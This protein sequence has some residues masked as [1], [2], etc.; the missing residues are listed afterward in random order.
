MEDIS[1]ILSGDWE[2]HCKLLMSKINRLKD[3][4]ARLEEWAAYVQQTNPKELVGAAK[5]KRIHLLHLELEINNVRAQIADYYSFIFHIITLAKK[6][7]FMK[8]DSRFPN[9]T[10]VEGLD[11][12]ICWLGFL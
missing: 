9:I 10:E 11:A 8:K 3:Y 2:A 12:D 5:N 1:S 6:D 7:Y 4:S